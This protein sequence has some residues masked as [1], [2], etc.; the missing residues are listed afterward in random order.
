[1]SSEDPF[2]TPSSLASV[3]L[4]CPG[5]ERNLYIAP[6][7][8]SVSLTTC[9][10]PNCQHVALVCTRDALGHDRL[11]WEP[12]DK[13][14]AMTLEHFI[15]ARGRVDTHTAADVLFTWGPAVA[16]FVLTPL[17]MLAYAWREGLEL[18]MLVAMC[19]SPAV[20]LTLCMTTAIVL[21]ERDDRRERRQLAAMRRQAFGRARWQLAKTR[22]QGVT[23]CSAP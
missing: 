9:P 18:L 5:C 3:E 14:V 10:H 13:A 23:P 1:M 11:G 7:E 16:I 17:T 22:P 4:R 19:T 21:F 2:R 12:A 8:A 6:P 20:L 15:E